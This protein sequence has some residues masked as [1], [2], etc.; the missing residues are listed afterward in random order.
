MIGEDGSLLSPR[1]SCEIGGSPL[2]LEARGL[3]SFL[4]RG[5]REVVVQILRQAE[6]YAHIIK[7]AVP[8]HPSRRWKEEL[9]EHLVRQHERGEPM[10]F[11][12]HE[13]LGDEPTSGV[14]VSYPPAADRGYD[15]NNEG[16][17]MSEVTAED[18]AALS[19]TERE[20]LKDP[21]NYRGG[22]VEDD[23]GGDPYGRLYLDISRNYQ[24]PW[25]G[26]MAAVANDQIGVYDY[27]GYYDP[28]GGPAYVD[29]APYLHNQ[30]AK[31]GRKWD[32]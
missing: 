12:L 19:P 10:G 25:E 29:T 16:L 6:Q 2:V 17:P 8:E 1:P 22:W 20:L 28:E 7:T 18:L 26:A 30:I 24:D 14:M 9:M 3:F 31:G 15:P 27:D 21:A 13:R 32:A 4:K 11:S 23:P 5:T